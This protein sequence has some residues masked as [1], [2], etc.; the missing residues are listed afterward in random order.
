MNGVY[1][2]TVIV[3]TD[4]IRGIKSMYGIVTATSEDEALGKAMNRAKKRFGQRLSIVDIDVGFY[5]EYGDKFDQIKEEVLKMALTT[6]IQVEQELSQSDQD[7]QIYTETKDT[8]D[9]VQHLLG[10]KA[11]TYGILHVEPKTIKVK[12]NGKVNGAAKAKGPGRKETGK[13]VKAKRTTH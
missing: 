7:Y 2:Y 5:A 13:T 6:L 11:E 8:L 3:D 10:S 4:S 12:Q 1:A 9:A